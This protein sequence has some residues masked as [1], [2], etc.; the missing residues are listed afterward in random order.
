MD[1]YFG[2][3]LLRSKPMKEV[4][5]DVWSYLGRKGFIICVPTN[6]S[7][8]ENGEAVMGKGVAKQAVV[9]F[10]ELPRLLASSLKAKGN[11]VS[12]LTDQLYSFPTKHNWYDHGDKKLI[13]ESVQTLLKLATENPH[14][15][16]VLPRPGCGSGSMKWS[17]IQPIV[18]IL[19]ENVFVINKERD[20]K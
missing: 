5:G 17:T 18:S 3:K 4:H 7:V 19:P 1:Q 2:E 20:Y 15:K 10:P 12:R 8:K 9:E 13:K 16:Y 6:E 14:I 11:V